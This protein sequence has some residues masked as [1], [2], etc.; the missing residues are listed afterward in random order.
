MAKR[1]S[2][3]RRSV[4]VAAARPKQSINLVVAFGAGGD[5]DHNVRAMA[6]Y[7]SRKS[8]QP[9]VIT[10]VAPLSMFPII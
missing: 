10:N 8:G 9:V 1:A 2:D 5:S 4:D 7:V 3:G 6:K